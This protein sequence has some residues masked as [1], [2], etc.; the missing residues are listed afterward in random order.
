MFSKGCQSARGWG[1][2]LLLGGGLTACGYDVPWADA[3]A[4]G[5]AARGEE[6]GDLPDPYAPDTEE[7]DATGVFGERFVKEGHGAAWS[8]KAAD[9]NNDG[10]QE[11]IYG[12]NAVVA[13]G[14]DGQ[15]LWT[16]Q[17]PPLEGKGG[18]RGERG[19][20][21]DMGDMGDRED[22]GDMGDREDRGDRGERG[23][24]GDRRE[25]TDR[26][27]YLEG[28][29]YAGDEG[30]GEGRE[31]DDREYD[32]E[33]ISEREGSERESDREGYEG[34]GGRDQGGQDQLS[35]LG[36]HVREIHASGGDLLVLDSLNRVHRING[37][38]GSLVWTRPLEG[39]GNACG[40]VLFDADGDDIADFF[41]SG[42][43]Q[44]YSG[45]T[46][47]P[48]WRA[49]IDFVP[50]MVKSGNLD[51]QGGREIVLIRGSEEGADICPAEKNAIMAMHG[52]KATQG[53]KAE[54]G[55]EEG[56]P[57]PERGS[58]DEGY[59]SGDESGG[60]EGDRGEDRDGLLGDQRGGDQRGGDG[61][62]GGGDDN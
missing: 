59:G 57:Q 12:G 49:D 37:E 53:D 7:L 45:K 38:D 13:I 50:A 20:R 3:D 25:S 40:F 58:V 33:A 51:G 19:D 35:F 15:P 44:A 42:G 47:E 22:R 55:Y 11:L 18:M 34:Q 17:L 39:D 23:E 41:P 16:F 46:G 28:E 30:Y 36:V 43:D 29:G 5:P 54:G 8:V 9:L 32:R 24:M 1:W 21:G 4:D 27:G 14:N 26:G 56:M 31:Y 62:L 6:P 61:L 2:L 52:A 60:F 10:T 48:L